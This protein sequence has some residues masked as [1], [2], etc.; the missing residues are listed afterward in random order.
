MADEWKP[1]PFCGA[2]AKVVKHSRRR[3]PVVY[4]VHCSKC[5]ANQME[6]F[7]MEA[8]AIAAWNTRA[9]PEQSEAQ[10]EA[11]FLTAEQRAAV[12]DYI[13]RARA[14]AIEAAAKVAEKQPHI[15][16]TGKT[17]AAAIRAL[18]DQQDTPEAR[19]KVGFAVRAETSFQHEPK[20]RQASGD[21]QIRVL[22]DGELVPIKGNRLQV[23]GFSWE[24]SPDELAHL[25]GG[26]TMRFQVDIDGHKG[27]LGSAKESGT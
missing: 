9:T 16:T 17:I 2:H 25:N 15:L 12:L 11:G 6:S 8:K 10:V 7:G 4:W 23:F 22:R 14:E 24:P 5:R 26:G 19:S 27:Q 1:C 18:K 20:D 3:K 13:A 21:G